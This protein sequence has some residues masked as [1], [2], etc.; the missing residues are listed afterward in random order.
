[1]RKRAAR[2]APTAGSSP[3]SAITEA[4]IR[5]S[6]MPLMSSLLACQ[7]TLEQ[8]GTNKHG[9]PQGQSC[10]PCAVVKGEGFFPHDTEAMRYASRWRALSGPAR[11]TNDLREL[12]AKVAPTAPAPLAFVCAMSGQRTMPQR[13][14]FL[15]CSLFFGLDP[16][17]TH[18]SLH[19]H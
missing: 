14:L 8:T 13:H 2:R 18:A 12:V 19:T 3:S 17:G 1:M 7:N 9:S 11:S 16:I 10:L 15:C 5:H 4:R 6:R